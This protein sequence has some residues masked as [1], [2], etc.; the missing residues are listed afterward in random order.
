[1][2]KR[3][4][5]EPDPVTWVWYPPAAPSF[6]LNDPALDRDLGLLPF[7]F[8]RHF[9]LPPKPPPPAHERFWLTEEELSDPVQR[10]QRL[11]DLR[12]HIEL[13]RLK[14]AIRERGDMVGVGGEP[15]R[16]EVFPS[17]GPRIV[18]VAKC[19]CIVCAHRRMEGRPPP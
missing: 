8:P 12:P 4:P 2:D 13:E 17:G 10:A 1:M 11:S 7:G 3:G 15:G 9:A 18:M 14:R 6:E 16:V 19:E 5:G